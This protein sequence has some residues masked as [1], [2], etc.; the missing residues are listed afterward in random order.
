MKGVAIWH[1]GPNADI[2]SSGS[3][4]TL[5][6][7]GKPILSLH[8]ARSNGARDCMMKNWLRYFDRTLHAGSI[9]SCGPSHRLRGRK[10]EWDAYQ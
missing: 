1:S 8:K 2:I 4:P 5:P 7:K 10:L 9:L 6:K 3:Q